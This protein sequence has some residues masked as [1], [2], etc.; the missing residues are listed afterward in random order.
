MSDFLLININTEFSKV[1][2]W[3]RNT[4]FLFCPIYVVTK[5][6]A[7]VKHGQF[8]NNEVYVQR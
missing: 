4:F 2:Q 6:D 5:V 3:E 7:H 1:E 8:Y